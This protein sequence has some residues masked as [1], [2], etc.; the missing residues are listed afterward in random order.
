MWGYAHPRA[1]ELAREVAAL[2][3]G[4][5]SRVF[6]TSGGSESVESAWKLA[7]EYHTLRGERRWKAISRHVA[8]HGT[9]MGALSINGNPALRQPFEPL[10]PSVARVSNTNRFHRPSDEPEAELTPSLLAELEGTI[11]RVG[12]SP[13]AI[14]VMEQAQHSGGALVPP[15]GYWAGVRELC[16]RYGILLCADEVITGFGR[17]G[18]WFASE[19]YDVRPDMVT[20]A[21]GLSSAYAAIGGVVTTQ[22]VAEPFRDSD[23]MFPHGIPFGGPPRPATL[24]PQKL[25]IMN[26]HGPSPRL[27]QK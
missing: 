19:R 13:V 5:L 21:K 6:F 18:T 15:E 25:A 1:I 10:V 20:M 24:A 26:H 23:A 9:T 8:Y 14:A 12:P 11:E 16:D 2:A 17:M 22:R 4:D 7:R 27:Q 3:P